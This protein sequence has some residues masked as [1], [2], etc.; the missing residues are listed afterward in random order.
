MLWLIIVLSATAAIL[1]YRAILGKFDRQLHT[2]VCER[3]REMFPGSQVYVGKVAFDDRGGVVVNDL[4]IAIATDAKPQRYRQVLA[5]ERMLL[6]GN[7]D[8]AHWVK[9]TIRISQLDLHGLQL[10]AWSQASGSWS[11]EKLRPQA[12]TNS[13]TPVVIVHEAMLK[14]HRDSSARGSV[15]VLHDI[16]GRVMPVTPSSN[17]QCSPSTLA[18]HFT[19]SSSGLI[20]SMSLDGQLDPLQRSWVLQ[21]KIEEL[22]FTQELVQQL[23]PQA[24]QYL[25]QV[26][27]LECQATL[28]YYVHSR[29]GE[30]PGFKLRGKL[31]EGRLQDA[32][33][34]YP[35]EK[36]N[37]DFYCANSLLQLRNL[38]ATSGGAS[39]ILN[40]DIFGF[41]L[42]VPMIIDAQASNLELDRR[43]YDSLPA[44][45][46]GYWDRL[47]LEG[48]VDGQLRLNFDGQNWTPTATLQ[49]RG[50][51]MT[52]WLFPYPLTNVRGQVVIHNRTIQSD[53]LTGLAGGQPV[54]G[55]F[56]LTNTSGQWHGQLNC[57]SGQVAVDEQLLSALTP[58]GAVRSGAETF[59]RT[60]HPTGLVELTQATFQRESTAA[61]WHRK[62]SANIYSGAISYDGFPYPI[63][64]IRGRIAAEDDHWELDHFEG[65][66]DSGRILCS[67]KWRAV[68]QGQVPILLEF[69][70]FAVPLEEEL[71]QALPADGQ[72]I[73]NQLQPAG[74]IDSI[75]VV[76]S[77]ETSD[78]PMQLSVKIK[79]DRASNQ[80]NGRSLRLY[81]KEF[82]YWL[83][84]VA[85]DI[86]YTPG[87]VLISSAS[88]TNGPSRFSIEGNCVRDDANQKW[89]TN[90]HWLPSTRLIVDKQFLQALPETIRQSLLRLDFRGP[91]SVLG[92]SQ[93]EVR[94]RGTQ[95]FTS[96]W[97]C[98]LDIEDAQLGN[99][100][101]VDS[102]RGTISVKGRNDGN[103][104]IYAT[105]KVQMDSLAVKGVPVSRL[106]GPFALIGS[107]IYFGSEISQA[108][109]PTN[110]P[111]VDMTADALA[112]QLTLHGHGTLDT[113]TFHFDSKLS[114]ADLT[115]LL[116]DVGVDR[117][118][119][120]AT[121]DAQLEFTGV[122]WNPQTY[123]GAGNIH[124][125]NANLYQLPF[126]IR[127]LSLTPAAKNDDA[128][129]DTADIRFTLDGDRIPLTI[130]CKGDLLRL[131]GEGWTNLRREIDLTLYTWV[132]RSAPVRELLDPVFESSYAM[133]M[134]EVG[135]TL[136]NPEM[137]RHP[138]PQL[139]STLQQIFPE[140]AQ[141]RQQNP[142]LPWRR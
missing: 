52:P 85:C 19:A 80:A 81:P 70:S 50:I 69:N 33:L 109:P 29:A 8:I 131:K 30:Y 94:P 51:S 110:G 25:T 121:C 27:G 134:I 38:N 105:G 40:T 2:A 61:T 140:V 63:R 14:I 86:T 49:C 75:D 125:S 119:T 137:Q 120:R 90:V 135:G 36:L 73:W 92:N 54:Q 136:D 93:V 55:D 82:P 111:P 124:L 64:E 21:G 24:A 47:K 59:V 57:R 7:L 132:G 99:G 3:L 77:R 65:R 44:T 123:R 26:A 126:M 100:N 4:R 106:Q 17:N 48:S 5:C 60:L 71:Q 79:E 130:E 32:R 67:G 127:L 72:Y 68:K 28:T 114:G 91:V 53:Q 18:I 39:L 84:D 104:N 87:Q 116:Q 58:V 141:R 41:Q 9:Q 88:A 16:Q 112:G 142:I 74:A 76:L 1:S 122:P 42:D 56:A 139:E 118:T 35:I 101:Y 129:F 83:T 102:M 98:E 108:L 133:A 34:P 6:T 23:P 20:R 113:G 97:D 37:G 128:A 115:A 46:R 89:V 13:C 117:A 95:G 62:L 96:S 22:D 138:F 107:K 11:I 10:D 45:W 103:Q 43:L 15:L 66:N 31:S 78:S 12:T